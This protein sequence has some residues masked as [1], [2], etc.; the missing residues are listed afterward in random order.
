MAAFELRRGWAAMGTKLE[1]ASG[2]AL[3]RREADAAAE[4]LAS[5]E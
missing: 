1:A 4:T 5:A 3:R 2:L